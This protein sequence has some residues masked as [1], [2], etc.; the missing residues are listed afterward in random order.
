MTRIYVI[1]CPAYC[2]ERRPII[3]NNLISRGF[4]DIVW[5]TGYPASHPFVK[6]LQ[7]RL[8]G[9]LNYGSISGLVKHLEAMRMFIDDPNSPDGAIFCDDDSLFVKNWQEAIDKI[10]PN[11]PYINLS[12]GV[13]FHFLPDAIPREITFNNGGC[14]TMWKSK[15]FCR[16]V[17][18]NIDARAGMDHVYFGMMRHLGLKTICIPVAQQTSLLTGK[19]STSYDN[20]FTP[21]Q[22][23]HIFVNNFKPTGVCY[24]ELWNESGLTRDDS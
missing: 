16:Y 17:L 7:K 1:H 10:P 21:F 19:A 18:Q 11:F 5:V 9:H 15:E 4:K 3:E 24:E 8:G 20:D 22:H 23:W 12:V 6:W 13:N 14:D 2:P